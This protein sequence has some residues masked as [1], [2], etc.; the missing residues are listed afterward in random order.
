M[1]AIPDRGRF[2]MPLSQEE[3]D[4]LV[5]E[6]LPKFRF[7]EGYGP[8]S[9]PKSRPKGST[10]EERLAKANMRVTV[11]REPTLK[12]RREKATKAVRDLVSAEREQLQRIRDEERFRNEQRKALE[13]HQRMYRMHAEQE[14]WLRRNRSTTSAARS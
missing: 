14:Y 8:T 3:I 5:A 4:E 13:E 10:L 6:L 12:E 1:A 2:S 11:S 7:K 9:P